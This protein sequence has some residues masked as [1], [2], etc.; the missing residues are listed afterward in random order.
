MRTFTLDTNC[1]IAIDEGRPEAPTVRALADAHRARTAQE[2]VVA[3]SASERQQ[4][5]GHLQSF[6]A[7]VERLRQLDL[8]H[9]DILQP[10]AYADITVGL[11]AA[12]PASDR[13]WRNAKCDVQAIWSHI[14][15]KRDVFVT[16]DGNFHSPANKARLITLGANCIER[17]SNALTLV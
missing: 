8:G 1:L 9:L 17:P 10:M 6:T 16:S 12:A 13:R 15:R 5:G 3:I 11:D 2:A 7:F 14:H 4:G